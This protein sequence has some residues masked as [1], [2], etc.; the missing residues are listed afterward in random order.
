MIPSY[1]SLLAFNDC[2]NKRCGEFCSEGVCDGEG[3][4]VRS[5]FNPCAVNGCDGKKCGHNKKGI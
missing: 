1:L 5:E 4:C 2:K 3:F